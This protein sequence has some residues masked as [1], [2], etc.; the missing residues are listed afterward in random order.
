MRCVEGSSLD[1]HGRSGCLDNLCTAYWASAFL[2]QPWGY[3]LFVE[4]VMYCV[5][6]AQRNDLLAAGDSIKTDD[7][8]RQAVAFAKVVE[9][10]LNWFVRQCKRRLALLSAFPSS[11]LSSRSAGMFCCN[12]DH[13]SSLCSWHASSEVGTETAPHRRSNVVAA[14]HR[15]RR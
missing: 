7:T 12:F 8:V 15:G 6:A 3:A 2:A 14:V 1:E 9:E 5:G 11:S 13:C 10:A 4:G